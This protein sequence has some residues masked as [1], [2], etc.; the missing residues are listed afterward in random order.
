MESKEIKPA[1][2]HRYVSHSSL[3][4]SGQE[5]GNKRYVD[6]LLSLAV[7]AGIAAVAYADHVVVTISLGYLYLLPLALS[8]MVHRRRV[9]MLLVVFC[10][11]LHDWFGP[12]ERSWEQLVY[13]NLLTFIGF[14][15]VVL[16][17]NHLVRQRS[18]LLEI[19]RIQRDE[20]ARELE[21][22]GELQ[23][24][25]LPRRPPKLKNIDMAG[26]MYP[27]RRVGGDYFDY[28][29]LNND[30][31]GLAI[32]DVSG[33]GAAAAL[34]MSSVRTAFLM[35]ARGSLGTGEV[36]TELNRILCEMTHAERFVSLFYGKLVL[37]RR[38][39]EFTNGGHPPPLLL[40]GQSEDVFWMEEGGP[41]LGLLPEAQYR[42]R[43]INLEPGDLMVFYTD[44][45]IEAENSNREQYSRERLA[46]LVGVHRS[47]TAHELVERICTS[48]RDFGGTNGN[49]DDV[50]VIVLRVL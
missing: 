21:L 50:A 18:E 27:A 33:K 43:S 10:V 19:V 14:T 44:G 9:T 8:A 26:A 25:L 30:D 13:R 15:S 4:Q 12:F 36:L 16:L 1:T 31:W 38:L 45:V 34:L 29:R 41:V 17:V 23:Q 40:R 28:V 49:R 5:A 32:A 24:S 7:L 39:F 3:Q 48:V 6:W 20:L 35:A 11:A 37:D 42:H 2:D 47:E 46:N 22:A